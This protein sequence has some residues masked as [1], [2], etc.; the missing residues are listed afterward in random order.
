MEFRPG[1]MQFVHNHQILH[2]RTDFENWPEPERQRHLLRLWLAPAQARELPPVF[3]LRYGSIAP[4][5]R[6]GIITKS[7]R[8]TF[9]LEA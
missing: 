5:N 8:L 2:S 9:S 1:D 6:G 4:G 7:T 3:G